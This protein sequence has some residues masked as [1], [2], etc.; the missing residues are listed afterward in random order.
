MRKGTAVWAAVM[1]LVCAG[2]IGWHLAAPE[3]DDAEAVVTQALPADAE[4]PWGASGADAPLPD[5]AT[6]TRALEERIAGSQ[7]RYTV[8][9]RDVVS[10]E[11]L[12]DLD[13]ATVGAPASSLKLLTGSAALNVLGADHRFATTA[14]LAEDSR[15]TLVGG[16]D[17]LLGSGASDDDAVNGHAGLG[18]LAEQTVK[19]LADRGA[20]GAFT[21]TVDSSLFPSPGLNPDWAADLVTSNN[22]TEIQ[23]PAMHAGR[24]GADPHSAVVRDPSDAAL[25]A[26]VQA[27]DSAA[28]Q[29][30][31]DVTFSS[32]GHT[33]GAAPA[34]S[35]DGDGAAAEDD[36]AADGGTGEELGTV[37]SATV[38]E[39]L[40][41][42]ERNSDN[43]LAETFGRLVAVA[44]GGEGSIDGA[45][46]AVEATVQDLG[47]DVTGLDLHDT[48]GLA[49]TDRI[50]PATLSGLLAE[51][52][53]GEHAEL[54]D[55]AELLPVS[56]TTGTLA[57]RL[58]GT[59][60]KALVRAKTGTLADIVSLSGYVTTAD[61]RLLSFSVM[62]S[63]VTGALNQAR[64]VTDA[65]ATEL[66]GCGCG[67]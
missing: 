1:V 24:S 12:V 17:V 30:G 66:L 59:D 22:I 34:V 4:E 65:I 45:T 27:L 14:V 60:T 61:G 10:G 18:T 38:L 50:S 11:Q 16:G 8:S 23:T 67:A 55:L 29:E 13:A 47:V 9:V 35:G 28:E 20:Q 57:S 46:D 63:G 54:R 25:A 26:Y 31:L 40:Q 51:A 52:Q 33:E 3:D 53:S 7:G 64:S 32:A 2:L 36:A 62:A 37:E 39:Q 49:A 21:V 5:T 56:G 42:M 41:Y 43:Y 19:A 44:R 58:T 15:V 48:S 6:L